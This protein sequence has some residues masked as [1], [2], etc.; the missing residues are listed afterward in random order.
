MRV[1]I[2][3]YVP[4]I[5]AHPNSVRNHPTYVVREAYNTL[6]EYHNVIKSLQVL[7]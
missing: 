3:V 1:A 6:Y 2:I 5:T 7:G 4:D